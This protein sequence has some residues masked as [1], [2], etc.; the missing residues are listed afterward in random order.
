M[1]ARALRKIVTRFRARRYRGLTGF[2]P[3]EHDQ[4][5]ALEPLENRVLLSGDC[6]SCALPHIVSSVDS[7]TL[8]HSQ[9]GNGDVQSLAD[10]TPE[11]TRVGDVNDDGLVNNLDI[12]AFIQA[13]RIGG[14]S[15]DPA[16]QAAFQLRVPGGDFGAADANEDGAVDNIDITVFVDLLVGLSARLANDTAPDGG[17]NLDGVTSDLSVTGVIRLSQDVRFFRAGLDDRPESAFQDVRS[18]L[19]DDDDRF[20]LDA[21]AIVSINGARLG[22]GPHTLHLLVEYFSG[23]VIRFDL[24]FTFDT[25]PPRTPTLDLDPGSDTDEVGDQTTLLETVTLAGTT[26]PDTSVALIET[27]QTTT[28][29]AAGAFLF[30]QVSL[31]VGDNALT[32]RATDAAGNESRF[33]QTITRDIDAFLFEG[34]NFLAE[35]TVPIE[36]GQPAGTRTVSVDFAMTLD[37]SDG[38]AVVEDVFNVYLV[39]PLDPSQTLLDRGRGQAGTAVFSLIGDQAEFVPGLSKY[40]GQTLWLDV[41]SLGDR[42]DA[43]LLFQLIN[44][45]RDTATRIDADPTILNVVDP[46]G[47]SAPLLTMSAPAFDPGSALDLVTLAENAALTLNVSN[48]RADATTGRYRAELTV[49]NTGAGIGRQ[50][51]VVLTGLPAGVNVANPGAVM[52]SSRRS[53]TRPKAWSTRSPTPRAESRTSTITPKAW[54]SASPEL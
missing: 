49:Q 23:Q 27:G 26:D 50:I 4:W 38:S 34:T 2:Q 1:L 35:S 18:H 52:T 30:E 19:D 12:S 40:D 32:V 11:G 6:Q 16:N 21:D 10:A 42:T 48:V 33:L 9:K 44:T 54:S 17:T 46:Q 22:N 24:A 37:N 5:D 31:A 51:A 15:D 25:V 20:T 45:D 3:R 13:L 41:T 43:L 36:L 53:P 39:D 47:V 7:A 28:A 8:I 14:P 29:D